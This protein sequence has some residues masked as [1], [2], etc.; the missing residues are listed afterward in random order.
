[1]R[2]FVL[3]SHSPNGDGHQHR[4]KDGV[5][6]TKWSQEPWAVRLWRTEWVRTEPKEGDCSRKLQGPG[7]LW[8]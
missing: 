6:I 1:M 5:F 2:Y 3:I 7:R 8:E 4:D